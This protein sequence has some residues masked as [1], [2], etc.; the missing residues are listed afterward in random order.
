MWMASF[1][2]KERLKLKLVFL[3]VLDDTSKK[4]KP[5]QFRQ[6]MYISLCAPA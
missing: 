5:Y 1:T 2:V 3:G 4:V 6:Y